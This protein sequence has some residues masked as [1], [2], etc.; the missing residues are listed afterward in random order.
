MGSGKPNIGSPTP[1]NEPSPGS[2][3]AID[4]NHHRHNLDVF[5]GG[6]LSGADK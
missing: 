2:N 4:R 5:H 3:L 6:N 1:W